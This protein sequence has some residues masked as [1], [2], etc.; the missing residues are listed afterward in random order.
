ME[1]R[2]EFMEQ[3]EN[4]ANAVGVV[5]STLKTSGLQE[6]NEA[7]VLLVEYPDHCVQTQDG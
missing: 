4:P 2:K 7:S 6:F 1:K 5:S 3:R